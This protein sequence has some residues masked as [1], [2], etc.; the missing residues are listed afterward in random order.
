MASLAENT[1]FTNVALTDDGDVW[2]EGMG[3]A[4]AHAIDW[5]G[6]D[7]TPE[8]AKEKGT[9]AAHP[10]S[11]FTA[12]AYQCPCIDKEWSNADGVP[13]SAFLFGG[14]RASTVPL[15]CQTA[16]WEHGVYTAATLGSETTAAAFGAQGVVRRDPFA[17][18]P[19]CG[20]NMADYYSH[21]L[22]MGNV[23]D[24]PV[25]IFMVNWFRMNEKG[26]FAWPG[27]GDNA[28][29]L[30]WIIE[31]CEAKVGGQETTLGWMPELRGHR[32]DR[33]DFS[34]EEFANVT[35]LD[36]AG[37]AVRTRRR[38]GMVRQDGR[39]AARQAGRRSA[40]TREAKFKA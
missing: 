15:V 14:R 20:Y 10:N 33:R 6:N 37:L 38:Q 2:W 12:P 32:L 30:K 35:S 11:R 22:K 4:P 34:K 19:F 13:I 26:K 40:T 18:L 8:I 27:F 28:R 29:V 7:W 1:I 39:Q 25:P 24:K 21:W 3:P 17:M 5:Q 36:K 31:R 23:A 16:D 9:K